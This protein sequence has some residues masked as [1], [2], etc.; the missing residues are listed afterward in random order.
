[1]KKSFLAVFTALTLAACA[2]GPTAF[3]PATHQSSTGFTNTQIESDR[4][5][6]SYTAKNQNEAQD[7][8]LL[9]AAQI[10]QDEGYSHFKI[11]GGNLS[12]GAARSG[13]SSSVGIGFGS[14]GYR[15][16]GTSLGV[17][18][19]LNDVV[20]ALEGQ[21]ITNSIEI[22]L[23]RSGAASGGVSAN[24]IYDAKSVTSSIRPQ[25]YSGP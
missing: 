1:M 17:G 18:L 12:G 13:I 5:R 9:R 15:R 25:V 8:A 23:L 11:I 6:V 3:G 22:R 16:G 24:D 21:R 7:F 10:A 4:F 14:G 19:G 20:G 2:T